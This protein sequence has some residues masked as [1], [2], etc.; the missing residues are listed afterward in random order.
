MTHLTVRR[1]SVPA[2]VFEASASLAVGDWCETIVPLSIREKEDYRSPPILKMEANATFTILGVGANHRVK[3]SNGT[4]TGWISSK[5]DLDQ[6]LIVKVRSSAAGDNVV[7]LVPVKVRKDEH[8]ISPVVAEV[9][10]GTQFQIVQV[11]ANNRIKVS[12][13]EVTG[14]INSKTDLNHPVI[15]RVK[16]TRTRRSSSF[17]EYQ[18]RLTESR[19]SVVRQKTTHAFQRLVSPGS[20]EELGSD[21]GD[22]RAKGISNYIPRPWWRSVS[23]DATPPRRVEVAQVRA[24]CFS[25]GSPLKFAD[26]WE[27]PQG[28][29]L[30]T[31]STADGTPASARH[32]EASPVR[33]SPA[34]AV[35]PVAAAAAAPAAVAKSAKRPALAGLALCCGA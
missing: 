8:Y 12:S 31:A 19:L 23:D 13:S 11:G 32:R 7:T 29:C 3:V 26:F 16:G 35:A 27:A 22:A 1:A 10:E 6:P 17:S 15:A 24:R 33:A 21:Q 14:W 25:E 2:S 30:E 34:P 18:D 9:P 4:V 28:L 20:F 5:T